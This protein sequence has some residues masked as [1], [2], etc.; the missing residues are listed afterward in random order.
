[1]SQQSTLMKFDP[2]TGNNKPYPSHAKQWRE[3]HG[4]S[5][6][7]FDPWTGERRNASDVGSD[8]FGQLIVPAGEPVFA[9]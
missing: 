2:A 6:W 5:A 8:A 4:K 7:L 3:Y 1:M 9:G